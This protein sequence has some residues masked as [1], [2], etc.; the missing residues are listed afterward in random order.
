MDPSPATPPLP[1]HNHL[2]RPLLLLPHSSST[3]SKLPKS[4]GGGSSSPSSRPEL[5]GAAMNPHSHP[6]VQR[7]LV[8]IE[9]IG[10]RFSGSQKQLNCRTVVGVLE[11]NRLPPDFFF[12]YWFLR[13]FFLFC[14]YIL[15][16]ICFFLQEAF[17]KFVGRPVSIFC[18]SRTVSVI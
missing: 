6:R 8:A 1:T 16:F 14:L 9:Y 13:F 12:F 17:E 7:Y 4:E 2:K 11:V 15:L 5:E 18:S 3:S 10:T